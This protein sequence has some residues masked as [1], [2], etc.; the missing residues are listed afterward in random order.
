MSHDS[1][2]CHSLFF[3]SLSDQ[4]QFVKV[5]LVLHHWEI[6]IASLYSMSIKMLIIGV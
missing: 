2:E 4:I 6:S 1:A 5:D 3:Q